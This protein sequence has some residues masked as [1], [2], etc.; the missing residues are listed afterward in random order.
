MPVDVQD[1]D[2]D[3][4]VF[5]GHK[6][7]GPTGIGV[8][9]AKKQHL[10]AMPPYMGGGD[11]IETVSVD[12]VT[13]ANPPHRFEAG[14]PPIVEAIGLGA[15][16]SYMMQVGRDRI[17]AHEATLAKYAHQRLGELNWLKIHGEAPGKGAIVSFSIDG[18][19]PHDISTIIDRSGVA[20]RAGHH[21]AQP[22]MER[23]GVTGTCRA[24]FA[25]YNTTAEID[26]LAEALIKAHEF[27]A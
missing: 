25:M 21:C 22:L 3:F 9:Y 7:Y 23:L 19:H 15:A 6:V 8:L 5:T 11:M 13:Y 10:D 12:R 16:L 4:F 2:C 20:V 17:A 18:L 24:S 27:F 1:L 14:T 26:A